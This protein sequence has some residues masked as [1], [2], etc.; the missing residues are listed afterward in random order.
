M[1]FK[2]SKHRILH[3]G[4]G[5]PH[6]Q[7]KLGD[8]RIEQNSAKKYLGVLVDGKLDMSQEWAIAAQKAK[9][10]LGCIKRSVASRLKEVILPLYST[11]LRPHLECCIQRWSPQYS[12]D[13]DL[14]ERIQRRATKNDPRGGTPTAQGQAER[15]GAILPGEEKAPQ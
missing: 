13:I 12:R 6:Y 14:L 11:L 5:K 10:I 8:K 3:L 4:L 9:L 2:K 1:R 7:Y 15:A